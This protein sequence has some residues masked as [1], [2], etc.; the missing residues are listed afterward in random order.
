MGFDQNEELIIR[1]DLGTKH[2]DRRGPHALLTC[3]GPNGSCLML[4]V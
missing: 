3:G 1:A 4:H 2:F